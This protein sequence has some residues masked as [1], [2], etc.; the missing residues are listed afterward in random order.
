MGVAGS[1]LGKSP[2]GPST[3]PFSGPS[4]DS[5]AGESCFPEE[6]V[7]GH[8]GGR[9]WSQVVARRG[10]RAWALVGVRSVRKR[11]PTA[12]QVGSGLCESRAARTRQIGLEAA[13]PPPPLP[14]TERA[15][16]PSPAPSFAPRATERNAAQRSRPADR[17]PRADRRASKRDEVR[18]DRRGVRQEARAG[19]PAVAGK[20]HRRVRVPHA[21]RA[22]RESAARHRR[23]HHVY[24]L[25]S[26]L[27]A[28]RPAQCTLGLAARR[29]EPQ[30]LPSTERA[31]RRRFALPLLRRSSI[32]CPAWACPSTPS[33]LPAAT[34][35]N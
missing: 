22:R 31:H 16:H 1:K 8:G 25:P 35:P 23:P 34:G 26:V 5:K 6:G 28:P 19:A 30:P 20:Q 14:C 21:V 7:T 33:R 9:K 32:T 27:R 15:A 11:G 18:H 10:R 3:S 4:P 17:S 2:T 24:R 12:S 29:P 13:G